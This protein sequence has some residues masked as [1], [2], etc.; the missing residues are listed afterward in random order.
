MKKR[1]VLIL[2]TIVALMMGTFCLN[3][4]K[5]NPSAIALSVIIPDG[6]QGLPEYAKTAL[7]N[8]ITQV[9]TT[10]G[11]SASDGFGRFFITA[12]PALMTKDIIP[13]PPQ[14]IAQNLDITFYVA[15]YF[16]QKIFASITISC[17]GV[18]TNENKAYLDA[19]KNVNPN[20]PKLQNFVEIGKQK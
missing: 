5:N 18:G 2:A 3:A 7:T 10:N 16:D 14:Q 8:K 12:V 17:K 15:D 9:A 11:I 19:I 6:F 4:Q 1:T 20:S 13:G